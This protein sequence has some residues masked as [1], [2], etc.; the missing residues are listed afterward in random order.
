MDLPVASKDYWVVKSR[1]EILWPNCSGKL[2]ELL[3][4]E[5][6]TV[7]ADVEEAEREQTI[8]SFLDAQRGDRYQ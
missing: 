3:Q 6:F 1:V 5:Y 2:R 4:N 7:K 8:E